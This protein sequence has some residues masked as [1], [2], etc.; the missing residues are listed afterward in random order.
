MLINTSFAHRILYRLY[1][2]KERVPEHYHL[3]ENEYA[4]L[5]REEYIK[6]EQITFKGLWVL[7]VIKNNIRNPEQVFRLSNTKNTVYEMIV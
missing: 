7:Y 2:L 5:V 4:Y 1:Y 6:E 3:F